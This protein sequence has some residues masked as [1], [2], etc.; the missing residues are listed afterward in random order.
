MG[1]SH[2]HAPSNYGRAFAIGIGLNL[3]FVIVEFIYGKLSHSLALVADA[4]HNLSDVL[5]LGF[6]WGAA[7]LSSRHP[8]PN[9]TYGMRRS[10][11]LA[12]LINAIT[13]L[14]AVG[15]VAWEA[16]QR[17][18]SPEPVQGKTVI[19]V[20]ATGIVINSLSAWLFARGSKADLN[21]RGAFL[22]LASD[23]AVSLGVVITGFVVIATGWNWLDPVVS[24]GISIVI[25]IGTWELLRDSFNLALDAVP[26]GIDFEGV[27]KYLET[28]PTCVDVHDMHIWG[29][30]T[31]E[32]ALTAHLI[33]ERKIFDDA[34]LAKVTEE[35]HEKFH[36]EHVTLQIEAGDPN[37]PCQCRLMP[38]V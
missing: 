38:R 18:R 6:A 30:S 5:G 24:L 34:M 17:F 21:I 22:H 27:Q 4:G 15:A 28:L 29:M 33:A 31:T 23:A 11:I 7:W 9:R 10:S 35:L 13:L 1:D 8:T 20:A 25:V 12:A 36:I 16:V 2:N 14:V 26:E 37:T 3:V 32:T 19:I